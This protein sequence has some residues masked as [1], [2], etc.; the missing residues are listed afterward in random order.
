MSVES[1]LNEL[2]R[3][4]A[5]LERELAEAQARPTSVDTLTITALKRR[6]LQL[7]EEITRLEQPV[8]LH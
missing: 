6:K 3:R 5:A 4:H 2:H 8:S 7:K 1:H